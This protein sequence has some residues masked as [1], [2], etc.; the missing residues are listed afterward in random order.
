MK[1]RSQVGARDQGNSQTQPPQPNVTRAVTY[2]VSITPEIQKE[3]EMLKLD[4]NDEK[5]SR[6]I[7]EITQDLGEWVEISDEFV[8]MFTQSETLVDA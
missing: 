5:N 8:E 1:R 3:I 6:K 2:E 4:L 7:V